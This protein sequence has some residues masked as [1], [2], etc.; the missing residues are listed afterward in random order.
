M[1]QHAAVAFTEH[2]DEQGVV[3]LSRAT[4]DDLTAQD[5]LAGAGAALNH[6]EATAQEAAVENCIE[7]RHM[8]WYPFDFASLSLGLMLNSCRYPICSLMPV[9]DLLRRLNNAVLR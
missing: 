6:V 3:T 1:R 9:S 7:T 5:R 4:V 8:A 2:G